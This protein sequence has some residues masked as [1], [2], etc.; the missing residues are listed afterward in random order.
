ME[1]RRLEMYVSLVDAQSFRTAA[2]QL[3]ISQPALSQQIIRL[4]SDLGVQ[5][6]DRSTRPFTVTAAGREFYLRCRTVLEQVRD[7]EGLL[8]ELQAGE[9]GRVRVGLTR[10]LVYGHLPAVMKEF[11]DASPRVDLP[12]TY[13]TT[14]QILEELEGGRQDVAVLYTRHTDK[15]FESVELFREPYLLALPHDHPLAE[16]EEIVVGDLRHEQIITIP[17]HAAPEVHDALVVACMK[18]GFSPRGPVAAGS[19]LDHVGMVSAGAG[20]SFLPRSLTAMR[21][22]NVVYRPIVE[23]RLDATAYVVWHPERATPEVARFV[24]VLRDAYR[25]PADPA[26]PWMPAYQDE[27]WAEGRHTHRDGVDAWRADDATARPTGL[28][29]IHREENSA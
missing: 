4:E 21:M 22:P 12:I 1:T 20:V 10:A 25:R 9:V 3:F 16:R 14:V 23:P 29:P 5:L 24:Q 6:L 2:E 17:R 11:R 19:Y 15:G 26:R 13:T 8:N 18:A 28:T 27:L 7:L